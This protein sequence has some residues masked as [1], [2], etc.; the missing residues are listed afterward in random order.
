MN[1]K[2]KV[3]L[4]FLGI[5]SITGCRDFTPKPKA[6]PRIT[7][8]ER[9]YTKA[10]TDDC[11]FTFEIPTYSELVPYAGLDGKP[12]WYNLNYKSFDATL[13]LSYVPI[14]SLADL[15]SLSED[16]YKIVF[17]PHI[18][19]AEEI[20]ER[21]L[22]DTSKNLKGMIYDL[23]GKTA[24]PFN[25]YLTDEKN[26]FFRGSF[27]FNEKTVRDSVLPIYNFINEDIMHTL[28][29]FEFR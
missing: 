2:H 28:E 29:S 17:K 1:P 27:Y 21:E 11:P 7:Y 3:L 5:F 19:R 22:S 15:D 9:A 25:F 13:H 16:A 12:C 24:T 10:P 14:S 6:Y 18:Q 26:H 23:E 8:P 20:I 4:L